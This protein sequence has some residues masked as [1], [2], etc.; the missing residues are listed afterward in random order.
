M[1]SL[2]EKLKDNKL[3][4]ISSLPENSY[5]LAK[6]AW[7]NGAD[8][9]KIHINVPHRA[10]GTLFKSFHEEKEQIEKILDESPIPVGLVA[11][12]SIQDVL[13]DYDIITKYPFDF[14]SLYLHDTPP[15]I[16][17]NKK[18]TCMMAC[19]YTYLP[20]EIKQ[21]RDLNVDILEASIIHPELYGTYLNSRDLLKYRE[22]VTISDL[23]VIVPSQ[24]K[25][26]VE[27]VKSIAE[28][29]IKGIMLGAVVTG[30]TEESIKTTI[31]QFREEIDRL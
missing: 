3:R 26:R 25:I 28:T 24:K 27:D 9:V 5:Q 8:A 14:L 19:D 11:G 21:F 4:V 10:S 6:A 20:S 18:L 7:E 15:E 1:T 29:G 16:L 31:A 22:L 17:T 2:Y 13:K 30:N 12:A 23:P